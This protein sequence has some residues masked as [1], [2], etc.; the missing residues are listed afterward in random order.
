MSI[1]LFFAAMRMQSAKDIL[2]DG[3][4]TWNYPL[5][6]FD[7]KKY[8]INLAA[9]VDPKSVGFT[10]VYDAGHVY[11]KETLGF[12]V[13]TKDEILSEK[14]NWRLPPVEI[15]DFFDYAKALVGFMGDMANKMHLHGN[16]W[17]RTVFIDAGG[18][19]TTEFDLSDD[20]VNMLINNGQTGVKE[21][22]KW[23]NDPGANP[24]PRNRV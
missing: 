2:V 20:Q 16:D 11:N 13:D 1:P 22:F 9:G 15:N 19:R 8:V 14:D 3:G 7:D 24:P 5:D 4:V 21:Y 10:T 6:L 12:R 17:D 23:F 18:V